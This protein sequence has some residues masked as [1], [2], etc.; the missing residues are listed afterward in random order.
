MEAN[1][2]FLSSWCAHDAHTWLDTRFIT[3]DNMLRGVMKHPRFFPRFGHRI[4][5]TAVHREDGGGRVL[6]IQ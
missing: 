6:V 3:R 1:E 5:F 2:V 4:Q